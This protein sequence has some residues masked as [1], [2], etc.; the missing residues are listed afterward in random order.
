MKKLDALYDLTSPAYVADIATIKRNMAIVSDLKSQSG[1]NVVLATKAFAMPAIFPYMSGALDGTTA[2]GL[3]EA[4]LGA[5]HFG[6]QVHTYCPAFT[7]QTLRDCLKY[8]DHIYFNSISQLQGFAVLARSI[9]SNVKIGLRMNPGLSLVKNSE[10]YDPSSPASRY[11]VQP[12]ELT[13]EILRQIDT[14][15]IHNLC[16]NMADASV[17]LINHIRDLIPEALRTVSN[18]NLGGGH[19]FTHPDYDLKTFARSLKSLKDDFDLN[20][21]IEPGGAL[22]YDSGYLVGTVLDIFQNTHNQAILDVSACTH[23]PDVLEVPYRPHIIDSGTE[24]EKKY[25]YKLGGNTCM[26][27]DIIGNYSF[28]KPLSI[29]DKIIFTDMMQYSFVKNN[30]FN[31]VPLPDL[32]ILHENQKIQLIQRFSYKDYKKRLGM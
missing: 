3:Y 27:G 9:R 19:Y 32:A 1:C 18:I 12:D 22:V 23:M 25:T 29:G 5:E 26:T 13:P 2:S 11:G 30:T 24:N 8:S 31:G 21:T 4:R 14:L 6:K 28:D 10:L 17:K 20:V 7:D 15:H 16:E